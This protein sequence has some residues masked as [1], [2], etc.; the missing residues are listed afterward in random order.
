MIRNYPW[1]RQW[2]VGATNWRDPSLAP[3][4]EVNPNRKRSLAVLALL[5]HHSHSLLCAPEP[6]PWRLP[7]LSFFAFCLLLGCG[8]WEVPARWGGRRKERLGYSLFSSC[9]GD[10]S[11]EVAISSLE[12]TLAGRLPLMILGQ[13]G[14]IHFH[15]PSA[16]GTVVGVI[17]NVQSGKQKALDV[18]RTE[19][20]NAGD[21]LQC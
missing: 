18:L 7:L 17:T 16:P 2:Q 20:F 6:S 8:P 10:V 19:G 1:G 9:C 11:L 12:T 14:F 4:G 3:C 21:L 5:C 15:V 13:T